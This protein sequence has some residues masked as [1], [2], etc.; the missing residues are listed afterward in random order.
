M[1]PSWEQPATLSYVREA[2]KTILSADA[3][4]LY[5]SS[6]R[7]GRLSAKDQAE[8]AKTEVWRHSWTAGGYLHRT[9]DPENPRNDR[10]VSASYSYFYVPAYDS[11]LPPTSFGI[12]VKAT[13]GKGLVEIDNG[14][15][16]TQ[17]SDRQ[18]DRLLLSA[19]FNRM[20]KSDASKVSPF[21]KTGHAV[22]FYNG[23]ATLYTDNVRNGSPAGRGRL[24]GLQLRFQFT[25]APLGLA[26]E[27]NPVFQLGVVPSISL[28]AQTQRDIADSG[29]RKKEDRHLYKLALDLAFAPLT[30]YSGVVP[31]LQLSRTIGSDILIGL[32]KTART[33]I[34]FGLSF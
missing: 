25:F 34:A 2:K 8:F 26:P 24:S 20:E 13:A 12:S 22:W 14:A 10:G 17:L 21:A 9:D 28:M 3:V 4:V 15:G 23:A 27:R 11:A 33:D 29:A 5:R 32:P 30:G 18:K 31:S 7:Y 6:P 19:G 1:D 16:G